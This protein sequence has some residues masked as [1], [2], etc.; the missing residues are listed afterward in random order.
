MCIVIH[1]IFAGVHLNRRGGIIGNGHVAVGVSDRS[2]GDQLTAQL[3]I[4]VVAPGVHAAVAQQSHGEGLARLHVHH[5]LQIV[6]ALESLDLHSCTDLFCGILPQL[7]AGIRTGSIQLAVN[8]QGQHM[9][10][11]RRYVYDI[12]DRLPVFVGQKLYLRGGHILSSIIGSDPS[13]TGLA[14]PDPVALFC[15]RQLAPLGRNVVLV[16]NIGGVLVNEGKVILT[17]QLAGVVAADHRG[18]GIGGIVA[19]ESTA[20]AVLALVRAVQLTGKVVHVAGGPP[21]Y[22]G[23]IHRIAAVLGDHQIGPVRVDLLNFLLRRQIDLELALP[24]RELSTDPV[25]LPCPLVRAIGGPELVIDHRLRRRCTVDDHLVRHLIA[26]GVAVLVGMGAQLAQLGAVGNVGNANIP[27]PCCL[28]IAGHKLT[29]VGMVGVGAV[30]GDVDPDAAVVT[31]LIHIFIVGQIVDRPALARSIIYRRITVVHGGKFFPRSHTETDVRIFVFGY[32]VI[33]VSK[34]NGTGQITHIVP[35]VG[36]VVGHLV[37]GEGLID[38]VGL[39]HFHELRPVETVYLG[40]FFLAG[41]MDKVGSNG[42]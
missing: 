42:A 32:T 35:A 11:P 34:F 39:E 37:I 13:V 7:T 16:P 31:L 8:R 4:A 2:G 9:I 25:L 21:H 30:F 27:D 12:R 15:F 36:L 14:T 5:M 26:L 29:A 24:S 19:L 33:R 17:H 20:F 22:A 6:T 28:H 3:S 38:A 1:R 23:N 10:C 41:N 18:N 40:Q